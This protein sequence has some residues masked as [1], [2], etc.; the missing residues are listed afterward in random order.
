[1]GPLFSPSCR[2]GLLVLAC[3][4]SCVVLLELEMCGA[5]NVVDVYRMIQYD[6]E[7]KP[8]GSRRA[9]MNSHAT[10]QLPTGSRNTRSIIILPFLDLKPDILNDLLQ[11][12]S[13][14]GGLLFVLPRD[15]DGSG[16]VA[17]GGRDLAAAMALEEI[18]LRSTIP[19]PVY[20]V[21]EDDNVDAML[22]QIKGEERNGVPASAASGGYKLSVSG[23]EP[24]MQEKPWLYN[25]QGL[26]IGS[27]DG[28]MAVANSKTIAVVAFYDTW[29]VAPHLAVGS[30]ING[31]G[32]AALLEIMRLFSHLYRDAS[33]R[34]GH[35]LLFLLTGGGQQNYEGLRHWL[36]NA[37]A[38]ITESIDMAVCL[39]GVGSWGPQPDQGLFLHVSKPAK[40][41]F[42]QQVYDSFSG[43]AQAGG[44]PLEVVHKKIN[45]SD[46]KLGCKHEPVSVVAPCVCRQV[47]IHIPPFSPPVRVHALTIP[48]SM[49]SPSP[50][51]PQLAWE[52][53][54]FSRQRLLA[55]T[56]SAHRDPA[57]AGR[58][59][60][61]MDRRAR[62][63][64]TS[65]TRAAKLV[66]EAV[67][68][69]I[70]GHGDQRQQRVEVFAPGS[71]LSPSA[72]RVGRW[73]DVLSNSSRMRPVFHKDAPLALDL[74]K[75]LG[76]YTSESSLQS[77]R[78]SSAPERFMF[79][80]AHK[81][82]SF[83]RVAS[84]KFD[85]LLMLA[86]VGYLGILFFL[87]KA[88]FG[89]DAFA[90]NSGTTTRPKAS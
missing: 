48:S 5:E 14:I 24:K 19:I 78:M 30:D 39:E 6:V 83:H 71:S 7:R 67:A 68:S 55:M 57:S 70:F 31:S 80:A 61:I 46:P 36:A 35:N 16:A 20:F 75:Y 51:S 89:G 49:P 86:V 84:L 42:V 38:R 88:L 58:R 23:P 65:V 53:E 74:L 40:D 41:P 34:G 9:S 45:M 13:S 11:N 29:G 63:N 52:H 64:A 10:M 59:P 12:A 69:V 85:L 62:V 27:K 2:W 37:D 18:L 22:Q 77:F 87:I 60:S 17:G 76:S 26:L 56:L 44:I 4:L 32:V 3:A 33:T 90:A 81:T 21:H 82:L 72:E 47:H 66:A 25:F 79:D 28:P 73:L 43:A 54:Q 15:F 8:M 50:P 1:M